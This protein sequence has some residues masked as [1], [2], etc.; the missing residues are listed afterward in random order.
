MANEVTDF[1][2]LAANAQ[3]VARAY[4]EIQSP[5]EAEKDGTLQANDPNIKRLGIYTP[6]VVRWFTR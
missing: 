3:V 5:Q 2:G 1:T 4:A 6:P